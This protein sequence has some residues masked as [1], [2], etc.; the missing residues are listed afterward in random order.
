MKDTRFM[1]AALPVAALGLSMLVVA[2]KPGPAYHAPAPPAVAATAYKESPLNFHDADGWKV[3]AP[4]DAML[5]GKW[6]QVFQEPELNAL[7]EQLLIDNQTIKQYFESY[8]QARAVVAQARAQYWPTIT[9]G[10][11]VSRSHS[12]GNLAGATD[13][14]GKTQSL[15][16]APIDVSWTPDFFGKLRNELHG[17]QYAAQLSA[18][19]LE[20]EKLIE[21]ASLAEYFFELRGQDNLQNILNDTVE[22]D[23]K[24]LDAAQGAFD[25]G[26]GQYISVVEARTTLQSAQAAATN[27]GLARAQYEHAI[28]TLLGK[29]ASDFPIAARP[30]VYQPP[31]IPIGVPSQLAERRPD[32]AAAERKLAEDNAEIGIGYG[33]FFPAVT[34][35]GSMGLQASTFTQLFNWPSRLWSVGPS[36]SQT[37]F[38]GHLY[39]AELHQYVAA[40]NAD[41]ATYRQTVLTA[42]QQV[43]DDLVAVRV[44]ETQIHQQE[45]AVKSAEEY[46]ALETE[47]FNIGVDP[48]VDVVQAQTTLLADRQS[49]NTLHVQQMLA[50]V[51]LIQ[52]LGG[53]WDSTQLPTP[54]QAG[55]KSTNADYVLAK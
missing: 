36:I 23:K 10:P 27:V 44:Y 45:E 32:V 39:R 34:L 40:Y 22:A 48:Y 16:S 46:L 4:Q 52:A 20:N 5:R 54:E 11:A 41:L 42:L 14:K 18:A 29:P 35:S 8:M 33:A 9:A 12:S 43:E 13:N 17:A 30:I 37:L 2:C 47:R 26:T 51:Q 49:L 25:A 15:W 28:A 3:A 24:S 53:G 50:S 31:T 38:D 55:A 19:D 1:R 6:W 21:Q 7:E